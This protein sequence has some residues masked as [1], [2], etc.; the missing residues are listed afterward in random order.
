MT[1]S[2]SPVEPI[3]CPTCAVAP[4]TVAHP[5]GIDD[6]DDDAVTHCEWCGAEYPMPHHG[7][8]TGPTGEEG[9]EASGES[10]A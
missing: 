9:G 8:S 3:P 5:L 6:D 2:N 10:A 4:S 7:A 1:D